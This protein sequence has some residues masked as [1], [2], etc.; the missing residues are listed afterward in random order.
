MEAEPT[1]D[2]H[3]LS[4]CSLCITSPRVLYSEIGA[5]LPNKLGKE[6][7]WWYNQTFLFIPIHTSVLQLDIKVTVKSPLKQDRYHPNAAQRAT[8]RREEECMMNYG[9][10]HPVEYTWYINPQAQ[11]KFQVLYRLSE[12]QPP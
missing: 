5:A 6:L 4:L 7:R 3:D 2:A 8:M 9:F 10:A 12:A 1:K 11:R